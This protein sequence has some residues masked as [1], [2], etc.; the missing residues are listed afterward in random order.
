[1]SAVARAVGRFLL[2]LALWWIMA[3]GDPAYRYY[4]LA[5]AALA[6]AL[7]LRLI[8]PGRR[9]GGGRPWEIPALAVWFV[10]SGLVGG[11]DVARRAFHPALP[12]SPQVHRVS[13]GTRH[14]WGR[15]LAMWM[16]NLMPGS[17]VVAEGD[18][19]ADLQAQP[20]QPGRWGR[21]WRWVGTVPEIPGITS[22]GLT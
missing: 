9:R 1:M 20:N 16:V 12:I 22:R 3:G 7:S 6:T 18:G 2:F 17:L 11:I 10:W 19:W 13:I 8:P 21:A 5:S 4:G 15:R 14:P